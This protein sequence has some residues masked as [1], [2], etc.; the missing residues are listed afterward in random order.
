MQDVVLICTHHKFPDR[1]AHFLG[2]ITSQY[3]PKVTGGHRKIDESVAITIVRPTSDSA[4]VVNTD[5]NTSDKQYNMPRDLPKPCI[6]VI[7]Y[8]SHYSCPIDGINGC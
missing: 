7:G 1:E 6:E 3:I 5:R 4:S 8:L 2:I